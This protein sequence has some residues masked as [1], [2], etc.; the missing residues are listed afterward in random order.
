MDTNRLKAFIKRDFMYIIVCLFALLACLLAMND[1]SDQLNE[2]DR[3]WVSFINE[4]DCLSQCIISYDYQTNIT[5]G[6]MDE[7][8]NGYT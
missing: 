1:I 6:G 5:W 2:R 4:S 7:K 3:E 8:D